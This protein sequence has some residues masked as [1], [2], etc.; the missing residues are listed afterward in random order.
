MG[1]LFLVHS[2]CLPTVSSKGRKG[3][4]ALGSLFYK[5]TNLFMRAH[6]LIT[7]QKPHLQI[8]THWALEFQH[9]NLGWVVGWTQTFE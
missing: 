2:W 9:K 8:S 1:A 3:K 6:D 7:S 5:G 4:G